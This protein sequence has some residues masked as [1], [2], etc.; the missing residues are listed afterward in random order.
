MNW[1]ICAICFLVLT[2]K[3]FSSSCIADIIVADAEL[4]SWDADSDMLISTGGLGV[5]VSDM[6][7][8]TYNF[9]YYLIAYEYGLYSASE[10]LEFT[11]QYANSQTPLVSNNGID[12]S[13][14]IQNF[15]LNETKYFAYWEDNSWDSPDNDD[16]YGW[17]SLTYT[18]SGL[19]VSDSATALG[20]G[21]IVGT[22]TQVPEPATVLLFG[23]G[24]FGAWLLR[25]QRK[26]QEV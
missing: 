4:I 3:I 13:F 19:V 2:F 26:Q 23:L 16:Y 7:G 6:G 5:Q 22:Y 24:G 12:P 18:A 9:S 14:S 8:G 20:G 11:P 1:K 25:R 17:V 15:S 10:G 21:V